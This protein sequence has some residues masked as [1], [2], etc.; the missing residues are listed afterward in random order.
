MFLT[1]FRR[2]VLVEIRLE[3]GV[4]FALFVTPVFH[5]FRCGEYSCDSALRRS[6]SR[7]S[8]FRREIVSISE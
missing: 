1:P 4:I 8:R 7:V 2:R 5:E 3:A 6:E